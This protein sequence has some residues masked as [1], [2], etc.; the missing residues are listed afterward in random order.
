MSSQRRVSVE[1]HRQRPDPRCPIEWPHMTIECLKRGQLKLRCAPSA[2]NTLNC[3][4]LEKSGEKKNAVCL[5]N[6]YI[7]HVLK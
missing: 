3:D 1:W 7:D 5:H 4:D 2:K 6:F